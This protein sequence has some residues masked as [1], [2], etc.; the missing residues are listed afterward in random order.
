MLKHNSKHSISSF[1]FSLCGTLSWSSLSPA[2]TWVPILWPNASCHP[3][4]FSFVLPCF[5]S[6]F[7]FFFLHCHFFP[8]LYIN[9]HFTE[10]CGLITSC[11][12]YT[13]ILWGIA[14][15]FLSHPASTEMS[16][17]SSHFVNTIPLLAFP[18][19]RFPGIPCLHWSPLMSFKQDL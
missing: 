18:F 9:S 15:F 10:T 5:R 2:A 16:A 12:L 6:P 7:F 1:V 4:R 11:C 14:Y 3:L 19:P 13:W 8:F 17:S